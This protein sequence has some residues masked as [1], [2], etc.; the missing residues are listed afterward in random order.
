MIEWKSSDD[1]SAKK[2]F[3]LQIYIDRDLRNSTPIEKHL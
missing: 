2:P 1:E 3:S